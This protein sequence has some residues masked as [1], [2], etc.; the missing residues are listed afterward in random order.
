MSHKFKLSQWRHSKLKDKALAKEKEIAMS[1][2]IYNCIHNKIN[3]Q[4]L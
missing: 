4:K 2:Q 3:A 1:K